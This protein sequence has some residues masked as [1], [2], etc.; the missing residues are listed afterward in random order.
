MWSPS[1]VPKCKDWPSYVDVVGE[2]RPAEGDSSSAFTPAPALAQ[3]LAAG[4]KPLYI[5][6]GSMVI[7]DSTTLG[8]DVDTIYSLIVN[9]FYVF[10]K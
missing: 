9:Y 10:Y 8:E 4:D 3:F 5:G 2:Y 1:F 7:E 6:F